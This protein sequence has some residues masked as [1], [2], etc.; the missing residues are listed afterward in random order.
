M[1]KLYALVKSLNGMEKRYFRL[2]VSVHKEAGTKSYTRLFDTILA[3]KTYNEQEWRN[4]LKG[5]SILNRF[6]MGKNYLY[7]LILNTLENYHR[8]SSVEQK[9]VHQLNRAL[10]LYN[11]ML[12]RGSSEILEKTRSLA[13]RFEYHELHLQALQLIIR[14]AMAEKKE[15]RFTDPIHQEHQEVLSRIKEINDYRKLYHRVYTF[16]AEKGNDLRVPGL[17]KSYIRFL[18]D[19]L[20]SDEARPEGY[21]EKNFYLLTRGL[22]FFCLGET[23]KS[24]KYT[25]QQLQL[26]HAYPERIKED[27]EAYVT[28]LNS[29][30]FYGSVLGKVEELEKAFTELRNFLLSNPSLYQKIFIAYDNMMALCLTEGLFREGL[31]YADKVKEEL[32]AYEE[33]VFA[34]NKVS[35]YHDMF[36]IYFGCQKYEASLEWLNRLLNETTLSVREDIQV[37]ARL[38]NLILHYELKNYDLLPYLL[39]RTYGFLSR[40]KRLNKL[41]KTLLQFVNKLLR[42][43]GSD[44]REM[45]ELFREI[46]AAM[47]KLTR[48]PDEAMILTEY[49]DYIGWLESKIENRSFEK[50][51]REKAALKKKEK[52]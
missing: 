36:Y 30:I 1:E 26:I 45:R 35:L 37:T 50:I 49:F 2:A 21:S 9:L 14:V 29:L 13:A 16:F 23:G 41:E 12:Y 18:G 28:A 52:N 27:P 48:K 47:E 15:R 31:K 19:P 10:I 42:V 17:R 40:R 4:A 24:Y 46:K 7:R 33:K 39:R 6:D 20:L 38:T 32:P 25:R 43:S 3:Q 51:V 11:K 5:D 8:N 34:S 22:C 44:K